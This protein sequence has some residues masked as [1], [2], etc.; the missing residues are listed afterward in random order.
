LTDELAG[1]GQLLCLEASVAK[2]SRD[3]IDEHVSRIR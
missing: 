1:L 3:G 2:S